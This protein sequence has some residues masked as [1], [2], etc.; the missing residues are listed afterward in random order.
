M[1]AFANKPYNE[2][3]TKYVD[4]LHSKKPDEGSRVNGKDWKIQKDAF[5]VKTL[6]VTKS[7]SWRKREEKRLQDK[8]YKA[9]LQE[10]KQEKEDAKQLKIAELKRRR[11]IKEEKERYERM[12]Q[13][14]HAKKVE[15]MR[16]REKRNKML[17]ER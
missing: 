5:R 10:L 17:K 12:A 16:K 6:G 13:K 7:S 9:R 1:S 4:P 3:P 8:Q 11:E 15:R 2:I 14:M